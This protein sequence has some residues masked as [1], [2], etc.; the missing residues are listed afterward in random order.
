[1]KNTC[2]FC[3]EVLVKQHHNPIEHYFVS[4]H[5]EVI[6]PVCNECLKYST[7]DVNTLKQHHKI[8]TNFEEAQDHLIHIK[9]FG[10]EP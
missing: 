10:E 3:E 6:H 4:Y 5:Y 1:V 9:M 7:V 2:W 8:F